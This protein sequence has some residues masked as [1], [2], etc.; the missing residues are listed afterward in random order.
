MAE[1]GEEEELFHFARDAE[2]TLGE[3][4][5][6]RPKGDGRWLDALDIAKSS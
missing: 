4:G 5:V 6:R 2:G 1:W 3:E